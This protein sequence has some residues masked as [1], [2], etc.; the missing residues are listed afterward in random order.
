MDLPPLFFKGEYAYLPA[1]S[2]DYAVEYPLM[3]KPKGE[4]R[5]RW[6]IKLLQCTSAQDAGFNCFCA[7]CC[8]SI[9]TWE[10]AINLVPYVEGEEAVLQQTVQQDAMRSARDA[11]G[12]QG[13]RSVFADVFIAAQGVK[14][15]FS[16][17]GVREQLFSVLFD[18]WKIEDGKRKITAYSPHHEN[19]GRRFIYVSCC[20]PC[21]AVQVVDA[22]QTWSLEKY[23]PPLKYGPI[24][25]DCKCCSLYTPYGAPVKSLPYPA[26]VAPAVP[27]MSR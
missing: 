22:V 14:T 15:N 10:N 27:I 4:P 25:W 16:R 2:I 5:N 9:W 13:G 1:R 8:C 3:G 21:A 26:Q 6:R 7:H 17:S 19:D 11:A 20:A 18:D 23:G 12:K 24:T